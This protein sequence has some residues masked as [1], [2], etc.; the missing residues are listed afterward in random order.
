MNVGKAFT[1]R[2]PRVGKKFKGWKEFYSPREVRND[3]M[4][5]EKRTEL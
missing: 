3:R 1:Q 4:L 5:L 2:M